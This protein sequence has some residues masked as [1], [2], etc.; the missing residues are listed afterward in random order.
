MRTPVLMLKKCA[1]YVGIYGT[2]S[3]VKVILLTRPRLFS[4]WDV[5][6]RRCL[7]V[8]AAFPPAAVRLSSALSSLFM[9]SNLHNASSRG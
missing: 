4:P 9:F 6:V 1:L 8:R 2:W 3:E 7:A 5:A